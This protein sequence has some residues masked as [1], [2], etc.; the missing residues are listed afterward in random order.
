MNLRTA[1]VRI[2]TIL[3][4]DQEDVHDEDKECW[5]GGAVYSRPSE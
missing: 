2:G 5:Q 3:P 4:V 1:R